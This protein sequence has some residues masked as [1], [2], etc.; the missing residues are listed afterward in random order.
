MKTY[1]DLSQK[2]S[3]EFV[4]WLSYFKETLDNNQIQMTRWSRSKNPWDIEMFFISLICV[5]NAII[6]LKRFLN[7]G[8]DFINEEE[9]WSIMKQFR[10]E[11]AGYGINDLRSDLL[12]RKKIFKLQNKKGESFPPSSILILGGCNLTTNEYQFGPY[13]YIKIS[14]IFTKVRKFKKDIKKIYK[15]KLEDF[16]MDKNNEYKSMIPFGFLHT[17]ETK[18]S[19]NF[20]LI[21]DLLKKEKL[22]IKI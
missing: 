4:L 3:S 22:K 5:D 11:L 12:H 15:K 2:E 20:K 19:N 9:L 21:K 18:P 6:G 1:K 17:F 8:E 14:E 13:H 10:K 16:Y 7:F